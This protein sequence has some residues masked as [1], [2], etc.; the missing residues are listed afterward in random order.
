MNAQKE[1]A[2]PL[3]E[4]ERKIAAWDNTRKTSDPFRRFDCCGLPL[5]WDQYN[6]PSAYG[7]TVEYILPLEDGG[8]DEPANLRARHW[9]GSLEHFEIALLLA[10]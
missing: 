3:T 7:W 5:D 4:E 9:C 6:K 10:L 1:Y 8:K 2:A